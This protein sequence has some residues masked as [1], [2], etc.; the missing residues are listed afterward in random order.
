MATQVRKASP[1]IR[2]VGSD[3]EENSSSIRLVFT[4]ED[5]QNYEIALRPDVI[6]PLMTIVAGLSNTLRSKLPDP[7][8]L[9]TQSLEVKDF[10]VAMNP[11]GQLGWQLTLASGVQVV[12]EFDRSQFAALD[13]RLSEFRALVDRAVH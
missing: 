8:A 9:P 7:E 1:F 5:G 2:L 12:L 13:A 4:G 6:A 11:A 3:L 10:R